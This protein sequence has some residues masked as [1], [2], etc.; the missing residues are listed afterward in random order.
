M[1]THRLPHERQELESVSSSLPQ[2]L[3][4]RGTQKNMV[5]WGGLN[6][7]EVDE[8]SRQKLETLSI[9]AGHKDRQADTIEI[10]Q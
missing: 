7:Q 9:D 5:P 4:V 8:E 2:D 1:G 10:H 3:S 6:H